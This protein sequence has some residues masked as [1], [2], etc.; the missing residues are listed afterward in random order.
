MICNTPPF[1]DSA[2]RGDTITYT[3]RVENVTPSDDY[4]ITSINDSL[5]GEIGGIPPSGRP[6]PAG[7]VYTFDV[8]YVVAGNDPDP[9][10]NIVQVMTNTPGVSDST[11]AIV[12]ISD[13]QL[14][15]TVSPNPP[16]EQSPGFDVIYTVGVAKLGLFGKMPTG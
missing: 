2:L 6:L 1:R 8:T 10:V 16:E 7:D 5:L 13:A 9:L 15:I 3:I 11:S 4:T 14:F 12:D